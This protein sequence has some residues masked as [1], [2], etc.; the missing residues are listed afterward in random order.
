M[1]EDQLQTDA[2]V[3]ATLIAEGERMGALEAYFPGLGLIM[4]MR[5]YGFMDRM[6]AAYKGAFWNFHRLSNGGFF[7][8]PKLS[9]EQVDIAWDG[10]G[11]QGGMSPEAAGLCATMMAISHTSFAVDPASAK[12]AV[13]AKRAA[14]LWDY[15]GEH[16]EGGEIFAMLD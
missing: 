14:Q 9:Q 10:N 8:A 15:I 16:P 6:C 7:M 11:Y 2:A 1:I 3:T 13:L 4:E 5:V 12:S